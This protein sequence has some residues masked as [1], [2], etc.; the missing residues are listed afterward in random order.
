MSK[1]RLCDGCGLVHDH[2]IWI[3]LRNLKKKAPHLIRTDR[4]H[5]PL[6]PYI[7]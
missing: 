3:T 5:W 4:N 2:D 6:D 1:D 7:D